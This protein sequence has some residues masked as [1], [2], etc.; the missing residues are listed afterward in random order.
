MSRTLANFSL[1]FQK[2]IPHLHPSYW[3]EYRV[4]T[5][6]LLPVILW[7]HPVVFGARYHLTS[8][9]RSFPFKQNVCTG[10]VRLSTVNFFASWLSLLCVYYGHA[11]LLVFERPSVVTLSQ[12]R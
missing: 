4:R 1:T 7:G 8:T 10:T 3:T 12:K 2:M 9:R 6:K 5:C 11:P